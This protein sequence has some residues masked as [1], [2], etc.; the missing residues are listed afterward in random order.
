MGEG[1][2]LCFVLEVRDWAV[3]GVGRQ[4]EPSMPG[5]VPDGYWRRSVRARDLRLQCCSLERSAEGME[6]ERCQGDTGS[7]GSEGPHARVPCRL[8]GVADATGDGS[9][10]RIFVGFFTSCTSP[11]GFAHGRSFLRRTTASDRSA[12]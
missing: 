8:E 3:F 9:D 1:G 7:A 4:V 11:A 5:H 6:E 10:F 12:R 2:E